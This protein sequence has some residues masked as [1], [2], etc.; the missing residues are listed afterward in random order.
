M[1]VWL[2]CFILCCAVLGWAGGSDNRFIR[3]VLV[4]YY[5]GIVGACFKNITVEHNYFVR[6]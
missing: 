6:E 5:F 1:S 3:F 4:I 2:F